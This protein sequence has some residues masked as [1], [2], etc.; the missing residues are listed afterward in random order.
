[1][2]YEMFAMFQARAASREEIWRCE[3]RDMN[4]CYV[5]TRAS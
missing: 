2:S 3:E 5:P 4:V 1:M